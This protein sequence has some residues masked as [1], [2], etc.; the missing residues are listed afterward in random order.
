M[1]DEVTKSKTNK[2][3]NSDNS[4]NNLKIIFDKCLAKNEGNIEF[5]RDS[6]REF[7]KCI[8]KINEFI[9]N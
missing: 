1:L 5:C 8:N 6:R 3:V 7:E 2:K 9:F 4:C